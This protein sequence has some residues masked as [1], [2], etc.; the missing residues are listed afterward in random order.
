MPHILCM[1]YYSSDPP[2]WW[3][4]GL[5]QMNIHVQYQDF[6]IPLFTATAVFWI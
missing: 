2:K 6:F 4:V 5:N 1:D 3:L